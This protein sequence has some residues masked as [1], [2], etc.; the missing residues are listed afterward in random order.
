MAEIEDALEKL[1]G[2]AFDFSIAGHTIQSH[3]LNVREELSVDR[4]TK[5]YEGTMAYP[6][7]LKTATF[8]LSTDLIDGEPFFTA[9]ENNSDQTA[10]AR[11]KKAQNFYRQVI[12]AWFEEYEKKAEKEAEALENLKK[13]SAKPSEKQQAKS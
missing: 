10:L 6:S 9:L 3:L 2:K 1:G 12:Q 13:K 11:F 5:D 8:A 7:A 4:L